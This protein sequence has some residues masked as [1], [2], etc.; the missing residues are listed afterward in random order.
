MIAPA[1]SPSA[2]QLEVLRALGG[3][4]VLLGVAP[5]VRELGAELGLASTNAVADH[6]RRMRARGWL[7]WHPGRARTLRLTALG[8]RFALPAGPRVAA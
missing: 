7:D 1:P 4:T 3:L 5:T 8:A 2:R 6:L